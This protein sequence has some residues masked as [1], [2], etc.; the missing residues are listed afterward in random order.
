MFLNNIDFIRSSLPGILPNIVFFI[1]ANYI[2]LYTNDSNQ[3]SFLLFFSLLNTLLH[4]HLPH[5]YKFTSHDNAIFKL[6]FDCLSRDLIS[7]NS[8]PTF[9]QLFLKLHFRFSKEKKIIQPDPTLRANIAFF[10]YHLP[11]DNDD[12][13]IKR[14]LKNDIDDDLIDDDLDD[15]LRNEIGD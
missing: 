14:I 15:F 9:Q 13:F 10:N 1:I 3:D 5:S 6:L 2:T 8:E 11:V 4:Q 7:T 12:A